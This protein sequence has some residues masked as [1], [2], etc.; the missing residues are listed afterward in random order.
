MNQHLPGYPSYGAAP[1]TADAARF[2]ALGVRFL[3]GVGSSRT[4]TLS[5]TFVT[6]LYTVAYYAKSRTGA[7]GTMPLVELGATTNINDNADSLSYDR[8]R[9][10]NSQIRINGNAYSAANNPVQTGW[11]HHAFVVNVA[12]N[13]IKHYINSVLNETISVTNGASTSTIGAIATWNSDCNLDSI[14]LY[15]GELSA[16]AIQALYYG[17]LPT[18]SGNLYA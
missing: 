11:I 18:S 3:S 15:N 2:G 17:S 14:I 9:I 5:S 7:G 10:A 1:L 16:A 8:F 12:G 4:A 13:S 6:N